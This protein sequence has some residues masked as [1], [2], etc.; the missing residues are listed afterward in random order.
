MGK[1]N[2]GTRRAK[3]VA[4]RKILKK[5]T[6]KIKHQMNLTD[7]KLELSKQKAEMV[8]TVY[9]VAQLKDMGK[10]LV[11]NTL[12][13]SK[14]LN[15]YR[16]LIEDDQYDTT[17]LLMPK[18]ELLAFLD[19]HYKKVKTFYNT[20]LRDLI[21]DIIRVSKEQDDVTRQLETM[22]VMSTFATVVSD[23]ER[24]NSSIE[25]D[26]DRAKMLYSTDWALPD[27]PSE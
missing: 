25:K 18:E 15:E 6:A 4:E 9:S 3:K 7:Q 8:D 16:A 22:D 19:E 2:K 26:L 14:R 24:L 17:K 21:G 20:T 27:T 11:L 1:T 5:A 10:T 13:M 12:T 23:M